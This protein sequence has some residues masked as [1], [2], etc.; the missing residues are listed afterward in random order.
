MFNMRASSFFIFFILTF[1]LFIYSEAAPKISLPR[2]K[3]KQSNEELEDAAEPVR[4][5]SLSIP[6]LEP[7][8]TPNIITTSPPSQTGNK[9]VFFPTAG[10]Y[11]GPSATQNNTSA[12]TLGLYFNKLIEDFDSVG[13]SVAIATSTDLFLNVS[14]QFALAPLTWGNPYWNLNMNFAIDPAQAL[15]SFMNMHN[16]TLGTAY[17]IKL[18]NSWSFEGSV[19]LLSLKGTAISINAIYTLSL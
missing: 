18:N 8:S 1:V 10:V 4:L 19:G 11:T 17:G 9:F 7:R 6:E 5:D 16:F 12:L 13:F 14:N 3:E 2:V 15:A